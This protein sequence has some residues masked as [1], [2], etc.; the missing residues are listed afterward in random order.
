[1]GFLGSHTDLLITGPS[2][3]PF[4][5]ELDA[6]TASEAETISNEAKEIAKHYPAGRLDWFNAE[7]VVSW[8][9]IR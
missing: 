6:L 1:M 9:Q 7:P 4:A 3:V 2:H 8:A 5:V